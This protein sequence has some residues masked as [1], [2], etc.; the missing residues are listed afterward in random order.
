MQMRN[1]EPQPARLIRQR[2]APVWRCFVLLLFVCAACGT[3]ATPV[4]VSDRRAIAIESDHEST[5]STSDPV[6]DPR[7]IANRDHEGILIWTNHRHF[8]E[9]GDTVRSLMDDLT[10]ALSIDDKPIDHEPFI[11]WRNGSIQTVTD[12]NGE[13]IGTYMRAPMAISFR[14]D[15]I[16]LGDHVP[17]INVSKPSGLSFEQSWVFTISPRAARR[18]IPSELRATAEQLIEAPP[19]SPTFLDRVE[20][21]A[22]YLDNWTGIA[23]NE[24]ICLQFTD[25]SPIGDECVGDRVRCAQNSI[26]VTIDGMIWDRQSMSFVVG[27]E[28]PGYYMMCLDTDDF[29]EGLHLASVRFDVPDPT[30]QYVYTWAF[31]IE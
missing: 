6:F 22:R 21:T 18:A 4:P 11:F 24:G 12:E 8:W 19:P 20:T 7:V 13:Q 15:D 28:T 9:L 27:V 1:S 31:R 25:Q 10:I 17:H 2:L 14:T 30:N 29:A 16:P 3:I 26:I 23:S 5:S